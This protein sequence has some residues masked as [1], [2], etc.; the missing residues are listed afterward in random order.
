MYQVCFPTSWH[1][2]HCSPY[3]TPSVQHF[4]PFFPSVSVPVSVSAWAGGGSCSVLR[5]DSGFGPPQLP[6]VLPQGRQP[7]LPQV[8]LPQRSLPSSRR[9]ILDPTRSTNRTGALPWMRT[10]SLSALLRAASSSPLGVAGMKTTA[11][12]ALGSCFLVPGLLLLVVPPPP[13]PPLLGGVP[14]P[15]R[16]G[17]SSLWSSRTS[18]RTS[19]C[20]SFRPS[21]SKIS[22]H[23]I[24]HSYN[25]K[26]I[27]ILLIPTHPTLLNFL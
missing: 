9:A 1:S 4:G 25:A 5:S 13:L 15:S 19:L 2:T 20:Q 17:Q 27:S 11:S 24:H 26:L 18:L 14:A 21:V 22:N 23:Y 6:P 10:N 16:C 12:G 8:L 3:R 7:G